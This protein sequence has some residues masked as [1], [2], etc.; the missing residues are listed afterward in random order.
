MV[1]LTQAQE[2]AKP[3]DKEIVPSLADRVQTIFDEQAK[4]ESKPTSEEENDLLLPSIGLTL[5]L[6][7]FGTALVITQILDNTLDTDGLRRVDGVMEAKAADV[8]KDSAKDSYRKQV[9]ENQNVSSGN[10]I[11]GG[12][13]SFAEEMV[14]PI[15]DFYHLLKNKLIGK[16]KLKTVEGDGAESEEEF[17]HVEGLT[18]IKESPGIVNRRANNAWTNMNSIQGD[19]YENV[20]SVEVPTNTGEVIDLEAKVIDQEAEELA[21]SI[22]S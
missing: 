18:V 16:K 17:E 13:H 2:E 3:V 8:K 11:V 7:I 21:G 14:Q 12:I 9:P 10:Q 20:N 1:D 4:Q 22:M 19:D 6:A 5:A 15:T